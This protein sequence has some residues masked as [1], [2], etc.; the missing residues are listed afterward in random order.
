MGLAQHDHG[1]P[2]RRLAM[3]W[4]LPTAL[5][6][7]ACPDPSAATGPADDDSEGTGDDTAGSTS[8]DDPAPVEPGC[9]NG[10]LEDDEQCDLG[11]AN[12][13]SSM[14]STSCTLPR[15]GDGVLDLDEQ[16]DLGDGNGGP[17]C[18]ASCNQP[19]RLTW[20]TTVG[21]SSHRWDLGYAMAP[22]FGG[23][24][25]VLSE[26]RNTTQQL[27]L[28]RYA[29]D[30]ALLWSQT[31]PDDLRRWG[32]NARLI[33]TP[34]DGVLLA[35][36]GHALDDAAGDQM[37][38]VRLDP[39]GNIRWTHT[40]V[41]GP[42]GRPTTG[43]VALAGDD[44]V[45]T[46]AL[47]VGT[48]QVDSRI[49]RVSEHDGDSISQRRLEENLLRTVGRSD[50][51]FFST[52][53]GALMSFG[54]DDQLQWTLPLPQIGALELA[55]DADDNALVVRRT[56]SGVRE[57]QAYSPEAEPLWATPISID[58]REVAVGADGLIAVAGTA[59]ATEQELSTNTKLAVEVFDGQGRHRW[60]EVVDGPGHGADAGEGVTI[61]GD[62]AV[63]LTGTVSVPF[64]ETDVWVGRFAQEPR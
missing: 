13:S 31:L 49:V 10:V 35:H 5:L 62:G 38:V 56:V 53:G 12:G 50:G 48:D 41:E 36:I 28:D 6:L 34:D 42:E 15:C 17:E 24:V 32:S 37:Q 51:G 26:L 59:E 16:C 19:E 9:G 57:L 25:V 46:L 47:L 60:R 58:P 33:S 29:P 30:G 22:L 21:G 7:A 45:M 4:I 18:S 23:S 27:T 44:V 61:A 2:D 52:G 11:F 54:A 55:V 8:E 43:Q 1:A 3:A 64:E 40:I 20:S 39:T 63:W 14:C